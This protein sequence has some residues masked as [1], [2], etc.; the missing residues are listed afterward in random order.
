LKHHLLH[1]L[2]P[3]AASVSLLSCSSS[4]VR[5]PLPESEVAFASAVAPPPQE[6]GSIRAWGDE[7]PPW[8]E[9]FL[10][11]PDKEIQAM[12]PGVY[13]KRHAYLALSGGGE[14]GAYGS[15][16]LTG[17]TASGKRPE[18]TMVT[19]ISTG[20]L[21]APF[22]FLGPAYDQQ[23]TDIYT[24]YSTDDLVKKRSVIGMISAAS[25]VD[26]A[27]LRKV[28]ASYVDA[29]LI[30]AIAAEHRNGRRLFIGT[31]NL[32][33]GRPVMWN[34]GAIANSTDPRA[35]ELIHKI[36]LASASIP[37]AF[38]P[39]LINVE[40]DGKVYDELHVDGGTTT[41]VFVYP[42]GIDWKAVTK[43]L[44]VPGRPDLYV[45]RNAPLDPIYEPVKP[46]LVPIAGRS[47]SSL[48][49]TQ[50]IGDTYRI[51]LSAQ[52]DGLRYHLAFIPK[53][54]DVKSEEAFDL[55][56]MRQL[57][58]VGYEQGKAGTAWTYAPPGFE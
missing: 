43:K 29:S 7:A 34:I 49:R 42:V 3:L 17:W 47:I 46:K 53:D 9:T 56:Y 18:F 48:I 41:Q 22:A 54:L 5:I 33:A 35:P 31:T 36:L 14:N 6:S 45:I 37:G 21:I 38:P 26:T 28:I 12:F 55:A 39:V 51:Y 13:G 44:K 8:I 10:D 52:R 24:K 20:S 57:Y 40:A 16:L 1:L 32:D 4:L 11:A 15:G 30:A 27:P 58:D 19:G 2:L 25:A 50:G 23:L